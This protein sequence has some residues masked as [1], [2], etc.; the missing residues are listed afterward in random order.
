MLRRHAKGA[1]VVC[2]YRHRRVDVI[3]CVGRGRGALIY[4]EG[5][6]DASAPATGAG[7][8]RQ[9]DIGA[10]IKC[11]YGG[12]G[13]HGRGGSPGSVAARVQGTEGVTVRGRHVCSIVMIR[14]GY[15]SNGQPFTDGQ[16]EMS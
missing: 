6:V 11:C 14:P 5:L 1:V 16:F 13:G 10:N 7:F 3:S 9:M 8:Q 12:G 2:G 15:V 4:G